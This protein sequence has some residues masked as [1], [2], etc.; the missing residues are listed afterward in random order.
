MKTYW[1]KFTTK[2]DST[3]GKGD[4]L[5]GLVDVEVMHDKYG[6]PFEWENFERFTSRRVQTSFFP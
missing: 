1:L 5:A 4:G 2:I 6:L 3:F